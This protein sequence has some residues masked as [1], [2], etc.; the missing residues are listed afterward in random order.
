[1]STNLTKLTPAVPIPEKLDFEYC[2]P[3]TSSLELEIA[4][5]YQPKSDE[6]DL[7]HVLIER[8]TLRIV[9]KFVTSLNS[10]DQEILCETFENDS[11]QTQIANKLNLSR[12]TVNKRL[13][14]ILKAVR[15]KLQSIN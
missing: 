5:G 8:E 15:L 13:G 11:N 1:M 2:F 14:K 3:S 9:Q 4:N 7:T 10:V 6:K 12:K